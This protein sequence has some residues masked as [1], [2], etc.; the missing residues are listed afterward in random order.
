VL[1]PSQNRG[2]VEGLFINRN[3][4]DSLQSEAI[5]EVR[6]SYAGFEGEAH[7]GLTR[8]SCSRV[9]LQ[10]DEGTEIRNTRQI[11]ILS[12]EDLQVVASNMNIS[13]I[14][15]EWIGCNLLVSGIPCLSLLPPS[16]RIILDGGV[17]IVVDMEN[18]PCKYSGAVIDQYFP[19]TGHLFAEA[20]SHLRGVTAWIEKTGSISMGAS[21]RIHLP[22]Q[23]RYPGLPD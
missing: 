16:T 20:A 2:R 23:P 15:P 14:K 21:I 1:V 5:D 22:V 4:S 18:G 9:K 13:H 6:V 8:S 10:Y 19:G 7:G 17:S 11:T 12:V 3:R